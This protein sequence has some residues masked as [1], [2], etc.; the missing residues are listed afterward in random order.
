MMRK[1]LAIVVLCLL[2]SGL[3][4]QKQAIVPKIPKGGK[5]DEKL[6]FTVALEKWMD[7][8]SGPEFDLGKSRGVGI[9]SFKTIQFGDGPMGL[10]IGYGVTNHA[11]N[12]NIN[13]SKTD[14]IGS[15]TSYS[16]E[17]Y[18]SDLK[19]KKNKFNTTYLDIPLEL[20]FQ[21]KANEKGKSFVVAAGFKAGYLVSSRV[22]YKDEDNKYKEYNLKNLNKLRYGLTGRI[23][24][25]HMTFFGYYALSNL[26]S[27]G[28]GG[29]IIPVS[30][31]LA[32]SFL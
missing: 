26:F 4:A 2:T 22:K 21:S 11:V 30:G 27:K 23:G 14:T 12:S 32:F 7:A 19:V 3:K 25:G 6:V 28:N 15:V 16:F 20:R 10:R 17:T 1:I 24:Y 18:P 31:G 29:E 13:W 5:S 8:P 9:Y